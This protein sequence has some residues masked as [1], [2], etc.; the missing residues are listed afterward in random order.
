VRV[1]RWCLAPATTARGLA[2]WRRQGATA[3]GGE[4]ESA[5]TA[6]AQPPCDGGAPA[7]AAMSSGPARAQMGLGW[8]AFLASTA[9]KH[10]GGA[11]PWR[12]PGTEVVSEAA[13]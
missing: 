2:A 6:L 13:D 8:P 4:R 9:G 12:L 7:G 10:G 11:C 1:Q 3:P 5:T